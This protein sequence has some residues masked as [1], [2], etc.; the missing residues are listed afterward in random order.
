MGVVFLLRHHLPF[1]HGDA[2]L[3]LFVFPYQPRSSALHCDHDQPLRQQ[4]PEHEVSLSHGASPPNNG[5]TL[6]AWGGEVEGA[7]RG[8]DAQLGNA[9]CEGPGGYNVRAR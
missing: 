1:L 4:W 8:G 9:R 5:D 3:L 2:C 6:R 7:G